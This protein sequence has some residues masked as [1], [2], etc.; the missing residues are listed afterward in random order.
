MDLENM[1]AE[2]IEDE[3]TW[4]RQQ[5]RDMMISRAD[6]DDAKLTDL[7]RRRDLLTAARPKREELDDVVRYHR[8]LDHTFN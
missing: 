1:T 2:Q 5:I 8:M 6:W 3:L 4:T 7:V